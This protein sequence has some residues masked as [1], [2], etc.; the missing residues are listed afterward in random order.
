MNVSCQW[1]DTAAGAV[2]D[3]DVVV[4]PATPVPGDVEEL[5]T[6]VDGAMISVALR[7]SI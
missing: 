3:V 4:G 2:G 1:W 6:E 7:I 5:G